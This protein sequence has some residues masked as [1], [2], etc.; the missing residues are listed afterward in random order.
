MPTIEDKTEK[1]NE[2]ID[3]QKRIGN[4]SASNISDGYHTFGELYEHRAKLFA[5]ICNLNKHLA[6]KSERHYDGSM[7]EDMFIVGIDTPEGQYSYHYNTSRCW[8]LFDVKILA[9]APKWDGHLPSDI[10][11][12]FSLK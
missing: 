12:L 7:F 3:I 5:V 2:Y 8:G 9:N 11:R 10:D 6:W 1:I 4:I